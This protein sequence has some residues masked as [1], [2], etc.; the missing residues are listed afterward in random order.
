MV[1]KSKATQERKRAR[2]SIKPQKGAKP[3]KVR[4]KWRSIRTPNAS[5]QLAA[6]EL[7]RQKARDALPKEP[8]LTREEHYLAAIK[9]PVLNANIIKKAGSEARQHYKDLYGQYPEQRSVIEKSE[10][11]NIHGRVMDILHRQNNEHEFNQNMAKYAAAKDENRHG[12]AMD[13]QD[14]A[15]NKYIQN[16][17][18]EEALQR[19]HN[20][21]HQDIEHDLHLHKQERTDVPMKPASP[22]PSP[23]PATPMSGTQTNSPQSPMPYV[24]QPT[25]QPSN[26][27]MS[28][29]QSQSPVQVNISISG[30]HGNNGGAQPNVHINGQPQ[31]PSST[32]GAPY[33]EP[34]P[35]ISSS[36][37]GSSKTSPVSMSSASPQTSP[38]SP[39][40]FDTS[41]GEASGRDTSMDGSGQWDSM[42][43][44]QAETM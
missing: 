4:H 26:S 24:H 15:V 10:N 23:P 39:S 11:E 29:Q 2:A 18:A 14:D 27:P 5:E 42:D 34:P 16:M 33:R 35:V 20:R 36:E 21:S 28:T 32:V 37:S 41:M 1:R 44:E 8:P 22:L 3:A 40:S 19:S 25:T 6:Y 31:Q 13:M 38:A 9:K 30:G 17:R 7:Q 43:H 12:D